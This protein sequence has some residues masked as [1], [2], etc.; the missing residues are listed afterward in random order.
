METT[1]TSA[2]VILVGRDPVIGASTD[3]N[4]NFRLEHVPV[5]NHVLQITHIGYKDAAINIVVNAGKETVLSV[6]ME[7]NVMEGKEVVITAD[8]RK[9]KPL[10]E[11]STVSARTF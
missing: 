3:D 5:G 10:N 1:L 6:Q 8:A 9:D 2:N 11:M 4:G 7:Q